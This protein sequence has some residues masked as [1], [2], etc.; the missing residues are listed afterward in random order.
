VY[1][2]GEMINYGVVINCSINLL[3]LAAMLEKQVNIKSFVRIII[4]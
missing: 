4:F 3:L 1:A 2:Y